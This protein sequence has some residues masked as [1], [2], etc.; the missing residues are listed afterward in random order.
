MVNPFLRHVPRE[1]QRKK[2][3]HRIP[4][5][6][7]NIAESPRQAPVP[8][9]F[10]RMPIPPKVNSFQAEIGCDQ[11]V[12]ATPARPQ[13]QHGAVISKSRLDRRIFSPSRHP[14]N[15]ANQRIFRKPHATNISQPP[16]EPRMGQSGSSA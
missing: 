6:G 3:R 1:R 5:H 7:R 11:H 14:A 4:A 9:R 12:V 16:L 2:Y 8:N 10:R 15:L 13:P